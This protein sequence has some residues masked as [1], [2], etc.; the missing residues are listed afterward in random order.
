VVLEGGVNHRV[1]CSPAD[2]SILAGIKKGQ[3]LNVNGTV[4]E[5]RVDPPLVKCEIH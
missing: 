5:S 4:V 2:R 1:A 3:T